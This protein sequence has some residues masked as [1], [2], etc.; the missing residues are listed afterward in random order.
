MDEFEQDLRR[1]LLDRLAAMP[2]SYD[3]SPALVARVRRRRASRR[4]ALV[5]A[6]LLV[7]GGTTAAVA[8]IVGRQDSAIR[9][10]TEPP[11]STSTVPS[12][13]S[14]RSTTSALSPTTTPS[15]ATGL[16]GVPTVACTN[17]SAIG[18]T[19]APPPTLPRA[20]AAGEAA[21]VANLVSFASLSDPKYVA[22][23]PRSWACRT[24]FSAD[25]DNLTAVYD[26]A[27][28]DKT[29]DALLQ[30]PIAIDN[31][32]LWHGGI[33]SATACSIFDDPALVQYVTQ[34]YPQYL[35]CPIAGRTVTRV[36][37][38]VSTFVDA[39]GARGVGGMV[40]P[41]SR[42]IDDGSISVLTC[43]PTTG[44]T[45]A[46]CDTI[47]ADYAARLGSAG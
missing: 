31:D 41:A 17:V 8:Q 28:F 45:A 19:P 29:V 33:G 1:M 47:V 14:A 20:P 42:N 11:T 26:P 2:E 46:D 23:G 7:V 43:R 24:Q 21:H 16:L 39:D 22:L 37:E 35:P 18:P 12:S 36:N 13:T 40:L 9:V 25:G 34:L 30:A 44:L 10:V 15:A 4:T 38:H 27:S 6:V 5:V 3:A 32:W